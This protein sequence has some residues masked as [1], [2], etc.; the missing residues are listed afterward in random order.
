MKNK[1][2]YETCKEAA[3]KCKTRGE[4][5]KKYS[6]AARKSSVNEWLDD[7]FYKNTSKPSGY[8]TKE[9]CIEESKKYKY[10]TDFRDKS[11][12]AYYKCIK[13]DWIKHFNWLIDNR[14][15]YDE[16]SRIHIVYVYIFKELNYAYV[17]RTIQLKQRHYAHTKKVN[18]NDSVMIFIKKHNL[19]NI[20]MPLILEE[21]L[22]LSESKEKEE[23]WINE[24]K[25]KGYNMINKVKGGSIGGLAV[26]WTKE[27][28]FDEAKKYKRKIDFYK[29]SQSAWIAAKKNGWLKDYVWLTSTKNGKNYW[30]YDK[31]LECA[32][33]S[34]SKKDFEKNYF[35]AYRKARLAGWLKDYTWF[36]RPMA[37][38]KKYTHEFCKKEINNYKKI[39]D[40]PYRMIKSIRENDWKDLIEILEKI[41]KSE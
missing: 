9:N 16:T 25:E 11:Y 34:T 38:N 17:G 3:I 30:T 14:K 20:D 2:N 31:C 10:Y 41:K 39:S 23:Y 1:W 8:W 36:K 28:C 21:K 5:W 33:K 22:T 19:T 7:F 6:A 26:K 12:S 32:K 18:S 15:K 24:Y 37:H 4:F 13:N 35:Q 40:I 27:K 29:K